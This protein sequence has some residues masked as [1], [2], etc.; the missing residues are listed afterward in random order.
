MGSNKLGAEVGFDETCIQFYHLLPKV[1]FAGFWL[2][3]NCRSAGITQIFGIIDQYFKDLVLAKR[4][5][6]K[7]V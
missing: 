4:D 3:V 5:K 1:S 7:N 2:V 6:D